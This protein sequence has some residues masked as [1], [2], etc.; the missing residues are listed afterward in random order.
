MIVV[1]SSA[2]IAILQEESDAA[3]FA[4]TIHRENQLLISAVNAH[5]CGVVLRRR[6]GMGAAERFWRFIRDEN[7]FEIVPFD[8]AQ[9]LV[10]LVAFDR[11]GKGIDRAGLNFADCVAYSLA[12]SLRSPLLFKGDDFSRTDIQSVL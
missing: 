10:A 8:E 9:A 7:D 2:I 3:I 6:H 11:Y 4:A 1:D 12:K 5:E